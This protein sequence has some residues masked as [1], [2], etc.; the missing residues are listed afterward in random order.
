MKRYK[1]NSLLLPK[2]PIIIGTLEECREKQKEYGLSAMLTQITIS[3]HCE[4][5]EC[6]GYVHHKSDCAV[7]N[8]PAVPNG[9]CDCGVKLD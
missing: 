2:I 3:N 6:R 5:S 8:E 1:L 4:C 7:H 9:K